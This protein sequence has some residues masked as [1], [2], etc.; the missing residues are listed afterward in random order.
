MG[1]DYKSCK[2]NKH[3]RTVPHVLKTLPTVTLESSLQGT[4]SWQ[5]NPDSTE[6]TEWCP[7]LLRKHVH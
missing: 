3:M 7:A 2:L 4:N 6:D 5:S 1:L